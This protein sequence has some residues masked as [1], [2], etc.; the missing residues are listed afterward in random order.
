MATAAVDTRNEAARRERTVRRVG[1]HTILIIGAM[2]A[3]FPF[4]WMVLTSLK[5]FQEYATQQFLPAVPQWGNY[6]QALTMAPFGRYLANTLFISVST[7]ALVLFTSCLAG[8][9]FARMNFFGREVIFIIFLTTLMIPFEI[10]MIPNFLTIRDLGWIDSYA[11]LIFPFGAS[12]FAIFLLRQFFAQ[13][14]SDYYDAAVLD[15]ASHLRFLIAIV[16]PLSQPALV[17]VA[18]FTFLGSWNSLLWPLIVTN[19]P[20]MRPIQVGL[21]SFINEASTNTHLLM[22]ASVIAVAPILV[23]Y[24]FA[25]KQFIEGISGSGLKG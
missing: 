21:Y 23:L 14:P 3:M 18:L 7:T 22:A 16:L 10:T 5:T 9:A 13:I 4:V 24:F 20:E 12:V 15:G 1:T 19:S 25:Q 11:A 17:S 2:I 6:A 8:Y